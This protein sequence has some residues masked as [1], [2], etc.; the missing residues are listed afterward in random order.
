MKDIRFIF[1]FATQVGCL[2][3]MLQTERYTFLIAGVIF[4]LTLPTSYIL[5][6]VSTK[7]ME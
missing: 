3:V 5:N 7:G 1:C 6:K 2:G 4:A